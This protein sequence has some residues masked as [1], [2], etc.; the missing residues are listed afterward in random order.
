MYQT[1]PYRS[2]RHKYFFII[3]II[4]LFSWPQYFFFGF[5]LNYKYKHDFC[6]ISCPQSDPRNYLMLARH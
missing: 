2:V 1:K 3:L 5:M 6:N 4:C